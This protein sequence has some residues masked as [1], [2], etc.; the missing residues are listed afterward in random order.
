MAGGAQDQL[1]EIGI[2]ARRARAFDA[3]QLRKVELAV[4]T[5]GNDPAAHIGEQL[6]LIIGQGRGLLQDAGATDVIDYETALLITWLE[7]Q[8]AVGRRQ[9]ALHAGLAHVGSTLPWAIEQL[10]SGEQR[11]QGNKYQGTGNT[12]L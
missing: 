8:L 2:V 1:L 3:V 4:S 5:T 11:K 7:Q 9:L 12:H 6:A 10:A